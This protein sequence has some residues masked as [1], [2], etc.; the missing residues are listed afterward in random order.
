MILSFKV[1]FISTRA[2]TGSANC[3]AK[4]AAEAG[5]VV[6]TSGWSC[7]TPTEPSASEVA[8][9]VAV[10]SARGPFSSVEML[11]E[12]DCKRLAGGE[13]KGAACFVG[14]LCR[15]LILR[16]KPMNSDRLILTVSV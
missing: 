6:V 7:V 13:S 4:A 8:I 12:V 3:I 14:L 15:Q 11:R 16:E 5:L 9:R 1:N 2:T 10:N